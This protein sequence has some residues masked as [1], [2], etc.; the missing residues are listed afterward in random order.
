ME[1]HNQDPQHQCYP[2]QR[3]TQQCPLLIYHQLWGFL[4]QEVPLVYH[5]YPVDERPTIRP[6]L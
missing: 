3:Q 1:D 4:H 2:P 6:I 5:P